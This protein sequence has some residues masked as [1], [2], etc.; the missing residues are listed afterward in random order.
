MRQGKKSKVEATVDGL[1]DE[2]FKIINH[3]AS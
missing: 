2:T 1:T 3:K